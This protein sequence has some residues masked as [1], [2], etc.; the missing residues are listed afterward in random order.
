MCGIIGYIGKKDNCLKKIISGL[1]HLEYRGY[2]SAGICYLNNNKL[3]I[4]KE[5]GKNQKQLKRNV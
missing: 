1:E 3:K 4:I 2:D 5:V